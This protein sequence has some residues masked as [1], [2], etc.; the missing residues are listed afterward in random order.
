MTTPTIQEIN[1]LKVGD[2]IKIH[3]FHYRVGRRTAIR[4]ITHITNQGTICVNMFG[5]RDFMLRPGEIIDIY[6]DTRDAVIN[7]YELYYSL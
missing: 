2:T 1:A 4:K 7:D 5:W 6:N 3:T